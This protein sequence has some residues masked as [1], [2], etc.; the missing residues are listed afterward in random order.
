M[1]ILNYLAKFRVHIYAPEIPSFAYILEKFL[2][3]CEIHSSR[4]KYCEKICRQYMDK[5]L[6][7]L[8]TGAMKISELQL[9]MST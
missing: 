6:L 4:K 3:I 7:E 2:H 1:T 9:H 8:Y 5:K